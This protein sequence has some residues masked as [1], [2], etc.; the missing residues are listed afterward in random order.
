MER[1]TSPGAAPA[2]PQ[3]SMNSSQP[4]GTSTGGLLTARVAPFLTLPVQPKLQVG[5]VD[6]PLEREAA[7]A[8][9]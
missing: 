7:D 3:A 9:R 6:D 4:A 1:R 5:S 8:R 2:Q